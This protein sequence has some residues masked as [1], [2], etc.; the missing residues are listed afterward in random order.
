MLVKKRQRQHEAVNRMLEMRDSKKESELLGLL[1]KQIHET[2]R[3]SLEKLAS[4]PKPLDAIKTE[5]DSL[6]GKRIYIF[7]HTHTHNV[8]LVCEARFSSKANYF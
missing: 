7:T 4:K 2:I 5:N 3:K 8:S 6:D 1:V